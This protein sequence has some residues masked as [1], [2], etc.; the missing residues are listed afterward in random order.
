MHWVQGLGEGSRAPPRAGPGLCRPS[1][2]GRAGMQATGSRS[3]SRETRARAARRGSVPCQLSGGPQPDLWRAAGSSLGSALVGWSCR[4]GLPGEPGLAPAGQVG[5]ME[6]C[7]LA[8]S[9]PDSS[10]KPKEL[11][12]GTEQ[13]WHPGQPGQWLRVPGGALAREPAHHSLKQQPGRC[14]ETQE[15]LFKGRSCFL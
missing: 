14:S 15:P 3:L 5:R 6:R 1:W 13:T 2:W 9:H 10:G 11:A 12:Q 4:T 7:L 8:G